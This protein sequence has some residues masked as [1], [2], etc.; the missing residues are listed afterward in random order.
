M[1]KMIKLAS[2]V[3]AASQLV[4]GACHAAE[5]KDMAK[6]AP[7]WLVGHFEGHNKLAPQYTLDMT[8]EANGHISVEVEGTKAEGFY[9]GDNHVAWPDGK[10][11]NLGRMA[12]GVSFTQVGN[13]QNVT[14]YV[15]K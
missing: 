13:P 4:I 7:E 9:T 3:F 11:S 15:K 1:N 14:E 12:N 10:T 2:V 6:P 5:A 8:V